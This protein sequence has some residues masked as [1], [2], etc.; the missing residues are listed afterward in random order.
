MIPPKRF[1]IFPPTGGCS[2]GLDAFRFFF[3]QCPFSLIFLRTFS[4]VAA[5][6]SFVLYYLV[7]MAINVVSVQYIYVIEQF[8]CSL[9][10]TTNFRW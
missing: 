2:E 4:T 10:E 9:C 8:F 7:G 3:T 6:L 5:S 1:D